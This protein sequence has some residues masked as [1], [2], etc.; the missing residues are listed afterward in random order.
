MISPGMCSPPYV[1]LTSYRPGVKGTYSTLQLPSLLSLQDIFDS[2]GPSTVMPRPPIPA[3]LIKEQQTQNQPE[4]F[5][6]IEH[7]LPF[8]HQQYLVMMLKLLGFSVSACW[9]PGP[10]ATTLLGSHP[11]ATETLNGLLGTGVLSYRTWTLWTPE[12]HDKQMMDVDDS[13]GVR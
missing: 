2:D 1:M 10:V 3:P 13:E 6:L 4:T 11:S 9:S 8:C 5:R 12:I 7:F